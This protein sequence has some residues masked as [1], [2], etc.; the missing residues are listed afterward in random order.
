MDG[1]AERK[2]NSLGRVC[3]SKRETG[4]VLLFNSPEVIKV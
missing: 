2:L 1:D 3:E 4:L